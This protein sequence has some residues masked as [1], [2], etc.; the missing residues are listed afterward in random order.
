[1]DADGDVDDPATD[2][3]QMLSLAYAHLVGTTFLYWD[4]LITLQMEIDLLWRRRSSLSA[5]CFF[6]NRYFAF[7][8]G[9]LSASLPFLRVSATTCW[10]LCLLREV[11][12][13][14]T[15]VLVTV[16][17]IIRIYALFGRSRVV[18]Y[19]MVVLVVAA[20][21]VIVYCFHSQ[22]GYELKIGGGCDWEP[23]RHTAYRLAGPW[24]ALFAFDTVIFGMTLY[25]A[26]TTRRANGPST[27]L[28]TLVVRDGAMYFGIVALANLA[29]IGTYYV[30]DGSVAP[31][32]L[33]TLASCISVTMISRL[34][35][36]LHRHATHLGIISDSAGGRSEDGTD[37]RR[38]D[39]ST[40]PSMVFTEPDLSWQDPSDHF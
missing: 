39:A 30:Q 26:Y 29:N 10:R 14:I 18:L 21:A 37:A 40:E 8:A 19:S 31:G 28:H 20:T 6:A 5:Y 1:M 32:A 22:H 13:V 16:I 36:N 11:S 24:E 33:T 25:S 15:Q 4:H 17:M 34:I 35:L 3:R 2:A 23:S 27:S 12:L 9:I 38:G 7:L